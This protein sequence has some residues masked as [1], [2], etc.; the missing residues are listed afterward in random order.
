MKIIIAGSRGI[1]STK[2]VFPL[3]DKSKFEITEVV[4]G[5]AHGADMVGEEW[6]A[7]HNVPIKYFPASWMQNGK[8]AGIFRNK[9]MAEYADAAIILWDGTS[10]GTKH[11]NWIMQQYGKPVEL[12]IIRQETLQTGN[13]GVLSKIRNG[14]G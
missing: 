12:H 11:M 4:S 1:W 14:S 5:T 8:Q 10:R 7:L 2:R 9:D 3:I 13:N 6:A